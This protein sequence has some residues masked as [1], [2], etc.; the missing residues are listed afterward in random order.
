[1]SPKVRT[2]KLLLDEN[3]PLRTACERLNS[4]FDVKHSAMDLKK[5]GVPDEQVHKGAGKA[6]RFIVAFHG[7]DF[8]HLADKRK[9]TGMIPVSHHLLK[10]YIDAKLPSLL[11]K[12]TPK[13]LFGKFTAI[14]GETAWG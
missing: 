2:Y 1:M 4:P 10:E 12:S 3:F 11:L 8:K 6:H 9:Q 14:T 7:E 13:T 5:G